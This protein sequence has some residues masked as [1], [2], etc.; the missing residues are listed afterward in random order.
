MRLCPRILFPCCSHRT[1]DTDHWISTFPSY[2]GP[3]KTTGNNFVFFFNPWGKTCQD[4]P[5]VTQQ[6]SDRSN[7]RT[8]SFMPWNLT[9]NTVK[10]FMKSKHNY[11]KSLELLLIKSNRKIYRFSE[12]YKRALATEKNYGWVFLGGKEVQR[13]LWIIKWLPTQTDPHLEVQIQLIWH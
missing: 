8:H 7:T 13:G 1:G 6:V 12:A 3:K 2:K 5:K 9:F 11:I 4:L 10:V